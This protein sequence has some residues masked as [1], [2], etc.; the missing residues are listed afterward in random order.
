MLAAMQ[1]ATGYL[2]G[3]YHTAYIVGAMAFF[4]PKDVLNYGWAIS[5][6]FF[7]SSLCPRR[8]MKATEEPALE[9]P[10]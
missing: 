7:H 6:I 3:R 5:A 4:S 10:E 9:M 8:K 2:E 1:F